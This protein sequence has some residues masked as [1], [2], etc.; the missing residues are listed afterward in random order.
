MGV[1]AFWTDRPTFVTGA[2]GF[3][4]GWLVS[5]LVACGADVVC[6][7]RDLVPDRRLRSPGSFARVRIVR[8]DVCDQPLIERVLGEYEIDTVFHLAA[9]A[10]VGTA[11][12]NPLS[13]FETNIRGTWT[14]LEACRRSPAIRQIVVASSDK[15]YG[16]QS[17]LPYHEDM[18]LQGRYP[19]DAS[20][21]CADLIAQS[22][23]ATYGLPVIISRCANLYGGG[24]FNWNRLVP[25]TARAVLR[26][27]RPIIRS[28]GRM[29]RD[30]M[31][32]EDGV[33]AYLTL[34]EALGVN[35]EL[36]GRAFN[37]GHRE[38]IR[39][40]SLVEMILDICQRK[41]LTPDVRNEAEREIADQYLDAS[42]ARIELGWETTCTHEVGLSRT[43][44][45][46]REF[47]KR[48]P[49]Q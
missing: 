38:P 47:M 32:V 45:W 37:F 13:T 30:Y 16:S 22:Y 19:Y 11:S 9:Q 29:L 25:G 14:V 43:V 23:A 1:T 15:A 17:I 36:A 18:A 21:S 8:G 10:V 44:E 31:Y 48:S 40:L 5:A 42:R 35:R 12:R 3:L 28:N 27:E 46:Y 41:D 7:E 26:G 2:T 20:K 33:M 24:D 39:V 4:G 49:G 34:A 6:L